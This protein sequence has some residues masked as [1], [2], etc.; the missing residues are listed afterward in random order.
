MDPIE[1][2]FQSITPSMLKEMI[3]ADASLVDYVISK[4]PMLLNIAKR[5]APQ[6]Q[7]EL[8]IIDVEYALMMLDVEKPELHRVIVNHP[9]GRQWLEKEIRRGKQL[10]Q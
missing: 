9:K 2:L 7:N 10:L 6:I 8:A 5:L 1:W 3:D 4:K